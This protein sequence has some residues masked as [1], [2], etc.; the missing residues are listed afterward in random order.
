MVVMTAGQRHQTSGRHVN[1]I[2]TDGTR[3]SHSV[4]EGEYFTEKRGAVSIFVRNLSLSGY[5]ACRRRRGDHAGTWSR[6]VSPSQ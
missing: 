4:G 6:A 2:K 1:L 3:V 5:R